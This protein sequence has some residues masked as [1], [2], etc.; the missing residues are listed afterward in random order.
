M[1]KNYQMIILV[2]W[3]KIVPFYEKLGTY[4]VAALVNIHTQL[5]SCYYVN[6]R[7]NTMILFIYNSMGL[8]DIINSG[9]WHIIIS[10]SY[11]AQLLR[12]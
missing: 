4:F 1:R 6:D 8:G 10:V 2:N 9:K 5:E 12:S 3:I 11:I 7:P